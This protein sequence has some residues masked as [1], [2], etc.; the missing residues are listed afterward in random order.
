MQSV[1]NSLRVEMRKIETGVFH[2][3]DFFCK[4]AE[5]LWAASVIKNL[6]VLIRIAC[7]PSGQPRN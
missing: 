5:Q 7:L 3:R 2:L 4:H 6:P 1:A